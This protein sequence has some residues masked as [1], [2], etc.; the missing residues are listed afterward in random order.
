V[1]GRV[2]SIEKSSDLIVIRTRDLPVYSIVPQ[3]TTL[4]RAPDNELNINA[5][6]NS[7]WRFGGGNMSNL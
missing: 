6:A 4:P 2:R 1:A 3:P 7:Q 5:T